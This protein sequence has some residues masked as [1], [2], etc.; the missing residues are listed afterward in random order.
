MADQDPIAF[1]RGA[2]DRIANAVRTVELGNRRPGGIEWETQYPDKSPSSRLKLG[3]FTGSWSVG[4]YKTVTLHQTTQTVSVYNWCNAAIA[5]GT[6]DQRYVIF[7]SVKG[8]HSA[9]ELQMAP[10][11]TCNLQFG[12]LDLT[13]VAGYTS[14]TIQIL[15][16]NA[17]GPCLQWYSI[18]TC[19]TAA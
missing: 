10:V 8:T 9:V 17:E 19:S 16:H 7:G 4:T 5:T 11:G 14:S 2:A 13:Q 12:S 15:G 18:T 1:T 3:T 6:T